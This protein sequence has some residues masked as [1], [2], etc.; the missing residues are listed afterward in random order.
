LVEGHGGIF[1]VSVN[2]KILYSNHK[3]C[4]QKFEPG[5]ILKDIGEAISP[6]KTFKIKMPLKSEKG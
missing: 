5:I 6:G 1:E 3:E 2:G 4:S